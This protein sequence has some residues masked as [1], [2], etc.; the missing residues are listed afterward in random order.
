MFQ[1]AFEGNPVLSFMK[2]V[3]AFGGEITFVVFKNKIVQFYND[4]ISD[5]W[6][7]VMDDRVSGGLTLNDINFQIY[8][9]GYIERE[10][11]KHPDKKLNF[12]NINH[13]LNILTREAIREYVRSDE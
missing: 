8:V 12:Q 6:S 4:D 11:E 10:Q 5:I 9:I 2:T 3:P 7:G 1:K 13:R